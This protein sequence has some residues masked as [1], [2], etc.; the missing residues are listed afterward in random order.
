MWARHGLS[1][2][3]YFGYVVCCVLGLGFVLV[4]FVF[5]TRWW[6]IWVLRLFGL[7]VKFSS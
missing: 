6:L 3:C 7:L 2:D 4:D 5:V 1:V